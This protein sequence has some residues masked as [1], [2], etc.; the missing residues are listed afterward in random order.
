LRAYHIAGRPRQKVIAWG[1]FE[2]WS[3]SI[4]EPLVWLGL[5]DPCATRKY[6]VAD[7]PDREE[8][9]VILAAWHDAFKNESVTAKEAVERAETDVGLREALS[10]VARARYDDKLDTRRIGHWLRKWENRVVAGLQ[11][12]R[13]GESHRATRWQVTKPSGQEPVSCTSSGELS[14]ATQNAVSPETGAEASDPISSRPEKTHR[15]SPNSPGDGNLEPEGSHPD[16]E[17]SP[18]QAVRGPVEVEF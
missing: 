6:V 8:A 9:A 14:S 11:L 10:A 7:D 12:R 15:N 18:P 13:D 17:N 4:R 3:R 16:V 5:A 1:G 2:G